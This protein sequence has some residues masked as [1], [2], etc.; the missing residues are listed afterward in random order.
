MATAKVVFATITGNNEDI[1][2]I[3]AQALEEKGM[4]VEVEEISQADP[5][6][7]EEVDLCVVCPYTYDEGS[8]PDEGIDFYEELADV[9]LTGKIYGVA[10]SGDTFYGE[11]FGLAIDKFGKALE[12]AGAKQ[13]AQNVKINL[14]PDSDEDIKRLDDFA[15]ALA[16]AV[17][18]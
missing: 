7:F 2:D 4:D 6:D 15:Q 10:G 17:N 11:Y 8:L 18:A 1:A 16:Q 13:G 12:N 3:I 5:A 14:A 9:D